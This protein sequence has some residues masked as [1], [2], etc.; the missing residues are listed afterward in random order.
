M[1]LTEKSCVEF[2]ELLSSKEPV[3]GGGGSAALVGAVGS[4]LGSMAC[5]LTIGKKKYMQYEPDVK[6]ILEKN[7]NLYKKLLTMIDED[8]KNFLPLSKA[9]GMKRDTP[10]QIKL[11]EETLEKALKDACK[12]PISILSYCYES[13]KLQRELVDK[14]SLIVIS[15]VGVGVQCLRSALI[16]AHL[17]IIVNINSIKN[18]LFVNDV[19]F[20]IQPIVDNGIKIADE[21]YT[22][23]LERM[24]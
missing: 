4:A 16:S 23:V 14:C 1:S 12:T 2:I 22:K 18:Q 7:I 19:K 15:D 13:I 5:N 8:A 17:N 3:P 21:V 11:K 10:E 9:Y 24:S 6:I 20:Q